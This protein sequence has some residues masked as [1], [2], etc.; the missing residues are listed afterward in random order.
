M[1]TYKFVSATDLSQ[2][3]WR[4]SQAEYRYLWLHGDTQNKSQPYHL[5]RDRTQFVLHGMIDL[6]EMFRD[7][8]A[9]Q[10]TDLP[11]LIEE[12]DN[13]I[14]LS[15]AKFSVS[16]KIIGELQVTSA[17]NEVQFGH[18]T[19]KLMENAKELTDGHSEFF[20]IHEI[21][22]PTLMN[23]KG[24]P[25]FIGKC[26]HDFEVLNVVAVGNSL[27]EYCRCKVCGD[28]GSRDVRAIK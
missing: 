5:V 16:N 17:L 21:E 19:K 13:T 11:D 20:Q 26:L 23:N 4:R 27:K 9:P 14:K 1:P 10:F 25:A 3:N 6:F 7:S 12:Y 8:F 2:V 18:F 15:K 28:T 24:Q 22:L